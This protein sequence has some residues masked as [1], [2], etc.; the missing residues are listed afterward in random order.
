MRD[1]VLG[2]PLFM[3][4]LASC[5][6]P[7]SGDLNDGLP[8]DSS[9]KPGL[10][11]SETP[12]EKSAPK[13]M[14]WIPAGA[15][16][17]GGDESE[18]GGHS[19]SH[20]SAYP[21]HEVHVDAFWID[22]TEVT[23]RQFAEFVEATGYVTLAERP[24]PESER[25]ELENDTRRSLARLQLLA[26][27]ASGE[28]R[29]AL[30]ASIEELRE[31][32]M[33]IPFFGALVFSIPRDE[34]AEPNDLSQ[35]WRWESQAN[36]RSPGGPGSNLEG[37]EDHPVVNVTHE[38]AAA[39]AAWVGKRL[40]TEAEWEKAA[41][42]GLTRQPYVW[43]S[44]LLPQ[45]QEVWMANIW[46]GEWPHDNTEADGYF[47]TAPVKSFPPNGY[48][49]YEIAGN[50]WEIVSDWYHPRAYLL[51]SATETNTSGPPLSAFAETQELGVYRVTKGGS[52]LCSEIWCKGYQP[53]S[54][55]QIDDQ[56]PAN[57]TGF[58]CAM[59]SEDSSRI[60]DP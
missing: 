34:L 52:F 16:L 1:R 28:D 54:R 10:L 11:D 25:R 4:L 58:R 20:Q 50:V 27:N 2:L 38:D 24:L 22:E 33:Q 14:V 9:V 56:S 44:D 36:W 49:L 60:P 43:G 57:H 18:K 59:D 15:Y 12:E 46:Q 35:W 51:P 13:G 17:R 42:G 7:F 47:T 55:D 39:Y 40:P 32:S 23:N 26:N 21:V 53:G 29:V 45:D 8:L 37:L 31:A 6:E 19:A 48:G 3:L 30:L 41:R 5:S